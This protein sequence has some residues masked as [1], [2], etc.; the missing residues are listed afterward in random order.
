MQVLCVAAR[1]T[2]GVQLSSAVD[3]SGK[4]DIQIVPFIGVRRSE[5]FGI[6]NAK[7]EAFPPLKRQIRM[8]LH[9]TRIAL[10]AIAGVLATT[11]VVEDASY[12]TVFYWFLLPSVAAGVLMICLY[13]NGI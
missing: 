2:R 4:H 5:Q 6:R 7:L 12:R 9:L 10:V 8:Y 1:I 3:T 13:S 11:P